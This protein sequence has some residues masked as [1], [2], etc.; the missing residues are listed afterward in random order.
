MNIEFDVKMTTSKM[1]DYML[2]HTF[3]SFQGI[4][5]EAVGL[6]L[7]AGFFLSHKW[8]YLVFGMIVVLYLPVTLL[9][10]AKK[11]VS[12]NPVFKT[13]L[14]YKLTDEGMEVTSGEQTESLAWSQMYKAVSTSKNIILYTSKVSASLFP[15]VDLGEQEVPVIEM[16]S[17][18]MNP[19]KVNLKI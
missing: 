13:P 17:T 11:Q 15:R 19:K 2:H 16:I 5:G 10:N 1:Y 8:P 9:L 18:H 7:L 4:L 12:L 3:T 14:H 6:L